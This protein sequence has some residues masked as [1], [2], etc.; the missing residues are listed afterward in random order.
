MILDSAKAKLPMLLD[1]N[2]QL[3]LKA[4]NYMYE[5]NRLLTKFCIEK[6]K[7]NFLFPRCKKYSSSFLSKLTKL[8]KPF[9]VRHRFWIICHFKWGLKL[10]LY[11]FSLMFFQWVRRS[12][13]CRKATNGKNRTFILAAVGKPVRNKNVQ[14]D[15]IRSRLNTK[16]RTKMILTANNANTRFF[17]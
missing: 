4:V 12:V 17:S 11:R 15:H 7:F 3:C 2:N 13:D 10:F 6:N 16:N 9:C 5:I 14:T 8:I 1:R